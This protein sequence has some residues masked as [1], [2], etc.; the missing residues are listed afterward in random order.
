MDYLITG[1]TYVQNNLSR[2]GKSYEWVWIYKDD[3]LTP[4]SGSWMLMSLQNVL[5]NSSGSLSKLFMSWNT[6][7]AFE[8]EDTCI[9]SQTW[10]R[11]CNITQRYQT[12]HG[13]KG[14]AYP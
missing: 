2:A 5:A 7:D 6:L 4:T 3:I 11:N 12:G 1:K 13:V 9:W 8:D 14:K 10:Q